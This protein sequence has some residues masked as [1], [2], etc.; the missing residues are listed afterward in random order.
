MN[1]QQLK[2]IAAFYARF[3][4]SF[5]Q[6]GYR[7]RSLTW[8]A[9]RLDFSG[10]HWL[11]TGASGGIGRQIALSAGGAGAS[12]SASARS[13]AKL[14][15]LAA[16]AGGMGIRGLD[17]LVCDFSL[18]S[19]TAALAAKLLASGRPID[20]LVN[21]V[22]VLEDAHSLTPEGRER[23]FA[24]NL[25]SHY[26]LTEELIRGGGFSTERPLVI[27]MTSGGAYNV[28]LNTSMLNAVDPARYNGTAAYGFHKRAQ[29][30]LNQHWRS[31]YGPRGFTFYVT[32]PGW[33]DT[34]GVKRSLP[35]FRRI[36]KSILRDATS[37]ADTALWLAA[38]R[39]PQPEEESVWF[40][41]KVRPAHVYPST[42]VSKDTA[43]SLVDS[44]E[45]ELAR[46][47]VSLP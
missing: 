45:R 33:A 21:N 13:A 15:T 19:D 34:D 30:V 24:V 26:L 6:V 36:L 2:K 46:V 9:T 40:D 20:V 8:H 47:P 28:P 44:L 25:L 37:G 7:A 14:A 27:N 3:T 17:A 5:S 43:V 23:S 32:H 18:Q 10:Q 4:L 41:R 16:D 1:V 35:R 31:R 22:G 12:V 11:V 39:P 42:R 29:M 38:T